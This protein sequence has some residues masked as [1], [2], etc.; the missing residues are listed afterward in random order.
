[1]KPKPRVP[2]QYMIMV[3]RMISGRNLR[4]PDNGFPLLRLVL[5]GPPGHVS[6]ASRCSIQLPMQ[7]YWR[8]FVGNQRHLASL[9]FSIALGWLFSALGLSSFQHG[10]KFMFTRIFSNYAEIS[11]NLPPQIPFS[12]SR[13]F[14]PCLRIRIKKLVPFYVR[15]TILRIHS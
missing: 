5:R 6:D 9:C 2:R 7:G 14:F 10:Y 4:L 11:Q 8:S 12:I 1:V 15:E 13:Q 3:I